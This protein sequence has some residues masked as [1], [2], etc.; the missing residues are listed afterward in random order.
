MRSSANAPSRYFTRRW[1]SKK[2]HL[3]KRI[4]SIPL[5]T[6]KSHCGD[7]RRQVH[8][9]VIPAQAGIQGGTGGPPLRH[10]GEGRNP[11]GERVPPFPCLLMWPATKGHSNSGSRR[12]KAASDPVLRGPAGDASSPA[13]CPRSRTRA[14]CHR[15][16]PP[17]DTARLWAPDSWPSPGP[18]P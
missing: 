15:C 3:N 18:P 4:R 12:P 8:H 7:S 6:T 11:E 14:G 13:E 2:T 17:C 10:S 16:R 5:V 1:E 9:P